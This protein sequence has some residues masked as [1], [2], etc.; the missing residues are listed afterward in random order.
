MKKGIYLNKLHRYVGICIAPFLITQTLS[1]LLL[2][3]GLFRSGSSG[4]GVE[5]GSHARN[6]ADTQLVKLHFGPGVVSDCYHLLLGAGM[7]WM[8]LS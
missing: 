4:P 8:A 6:L 3:F 7:V 1:G 2:D 5:V